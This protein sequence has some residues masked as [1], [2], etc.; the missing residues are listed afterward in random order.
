ML[1]LLT[2]SLYRVVLLMVYVCMSRELQDVLS[3]MDS[4]V[5]ETRAATRKSKSKTN[6]KS[7]NNATNT[8]SAAGKAGSMKAKASTDV[9][10]S[11]GTKTTTTSPRHSDIQQQQ[12]QKKQTTNAVSKSKAGGSS[13][14]AIDRTRSNSI[15]TCYF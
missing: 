1:H 5:S 4:V 10:S 6:Q 11:K 13:R 12:Q 3:S 15:G 14:N 8:S 7:A 9:Q 2:S